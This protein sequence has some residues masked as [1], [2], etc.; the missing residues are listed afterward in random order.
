MLS[1]THIYNIVRFSS[2]V[3]GR[4]PSLSRL[5]FGSMAAV[6]TRHSLTQL[7]SELTV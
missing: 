1:N 4:G 6:A 2:G 5:F 3:A 7:D